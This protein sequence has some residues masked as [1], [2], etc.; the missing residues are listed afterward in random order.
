MK[1]KNDE[2]IFKSVDGREIGAPPFSFS[3]SAAQLRWNESIWMRYFTRAWYGKFQS[4]R[5]MI[6]IATTTL[7]P[8]GNRRL[9]K[10]SIRCSNGEFLS[11]PSSSSWFMFRGFFLCGFFEFRVRNWREYNENWRQN[12]KKKKEKEMINIK[13]LSGR[14]CSWEIR[15]RALSRKTFSK[16]HITDCI[17]S[18]ES[19]YSTLYSNIFV[20]IYIFVCVCVCVF[21]LSVES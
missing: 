12:K 18:N 5:S 19:I 20:F 16:V 11:S 2:F 6:Q 8:T 17:S 13:M 9:F 4:L 10:W 15:S 3:F 1:M 7:F 21:Y 14:G